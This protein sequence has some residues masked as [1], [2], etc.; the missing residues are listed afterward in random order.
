MPSSLF[1]RERRR[2]LASFLAAPFIYHT[3]EFRRR[4]EAVARRNLTSLLASP[5]YRQ[6]RF[7]AWLRSIA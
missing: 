4:Y 1:Y 5:R 2:L 3:D 7:T 6:G